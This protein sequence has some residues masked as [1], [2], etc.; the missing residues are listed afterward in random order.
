MR[1]ER[2]NHEAVAGEESALDD[3]ADGREQ[4]V[5]LLALELARQTADVHFG[6]REG[7][8]RPTRARVP[9]GPA[10]ASTPAAAC[11]PEPTVATTAT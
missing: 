9:R 5:Q 3:V 7:H 11:A 10:A 4:V 8:R 2:A 1:A 6:G